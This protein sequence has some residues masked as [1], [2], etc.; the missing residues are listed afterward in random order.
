MPTTAPAV[1]TIGIPTFGS[2]PLAASLS[3]ATGLLTMTL[4]PT[5]SPAPDFYIYRASKPVSPGVSAKQE[6]EIILTAT[7]SSPASASALG[8]AYIT[9]FGTP[10]TG[11]QMFASCIPVKTGF[12][13]TEQIFNAIIA[14]SS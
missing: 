7:G 8:A 4:T 10:A 13:G 12:Q 5:L 11:K 2:T 6:L 1:P 3:T 14:S 9:K